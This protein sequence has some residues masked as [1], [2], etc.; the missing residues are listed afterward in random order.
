MRE[1]RE[2]EVWE[3]FSET[4]ARIVEQLQ[5]ELLRERGLP[6]AWYE[7]LMRLAAGP[8]GR[9]R[10]QEL[11]DRMQLSKSGLTRLADRLEI[12][13]LVRRE[14][15]P[16]DRRGTYAAITDQGLATLR[17]A[18]PVHLAGVRRHFLDP[19]TTAQLKSL[20]ETL[21]ELRGRNRRPA[22]LS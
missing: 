3:A 12:A 6:L 22:L 13:G 7:L 21:G 14:V 19:L 17:E 9:L 10:M 2:L 18:A 4:H 20:E 11:A 1:G 16:S 15:C 8:G 5:R